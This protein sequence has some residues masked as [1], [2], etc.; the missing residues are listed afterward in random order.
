MAFSALLTFALSK[1]EKRFGLPITKYISLN[2]NVNGRIEYKNQ[3]KEKEQIILDSIK[4]TYKYVVSLIEKINSYI[5][6]S[7]IENLVFAISEEGY[8]II[9]DKRIDNI[10]FYIVSYFKIFY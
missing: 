10:L 3:F 1:S 8:L 2:I 9:I 6:S 4:S 5:E 7:I